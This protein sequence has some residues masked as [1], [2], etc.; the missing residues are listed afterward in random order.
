MT[1]EKT[2]V[3]NE[4]I[5]EEQEVVIDEVKSEPAKPT[6]DPGV[7][8]NNLYNVDVTSHLEEKNGLTYLSWAWAWAE[9]CKVYPTA[10]YE[11]TYYKDQNGNDVPFQDLGVLGCLVRTSITVDGMTRTMSL[12]VMD[13]SNRAMKTVP[14]DYE[15]KDKKGNTYTKTVKAYDIMDINKTLWRCLVKNIAMFGLGLKVYSGDDLPPSIDP[16]T[17][18]V[19]E[20]NYPKMKK[21]GNVA[22]DNVDGSASNSNL[23]SEK[24]LALIKKLYAPTYLA[25]VCKQL[26]ID[27]I[28]NIDKKN[29]SK[30]IE[31]AKKQK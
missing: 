31:N 19:I 11:F 9:L 13:A 1:N 28:S 29:A 12:P 14:Y 30:L 7:I 25:A 10:T 26:K 3:K 15:V 20:K 6:T 8:F 17:G 27:D 16:V 22:A 2:N 18:E 24:Q 5:K 23:V 21:G 4:K